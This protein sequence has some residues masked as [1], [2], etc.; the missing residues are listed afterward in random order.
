MGK[1]RQKKKSSKR[2]I[3]PL[4]RKVIEA[5]IREANSKI[6]IPT[7]EQVAPVVERLS[8]EDP[9]ERAWAAACI[10][11]LILANAATRK[12]LLSKGIVSTLIQRLADPQQEVRDESLGALRNI[13]SVE[14]TV[15]KEYYTRNI[16]E[17]LSA[18]LPQITQTIDMVLKKAPLEDEADGD[19]RK[20]IWD[21]TENF[22]Y[23]IWCISEASDKYIK[24]INRMNI[25]TFLSS[26]LISGE[27]I[28][29][30]VIIAAGQCLNTLTDDN[31]DLYIEFQ[32]HPEYVQTLLNI[33]RQQ[34]GN[35]LI[36]VL[37]CAILMNVRDVVNLSTSWD[38]DHQDMEELNKLVIPELVRALDYDIQ[39]AAN[40]TISAVQSGNV[41]NTQ[42]ESNE[43]TP[44]PKQP[45]TNEEIYVQ[46]VED[47]LSIT[48]LALELLADICVQDDELDDGFQDSDQVMQDDEDDEQP[49]QETDNDNDI[50]PAI[51]NNTAQDDE[52]LQ[53]NPVLHAYIHQ[54]FPQLIRLATATPISYNQTNLHPTVTHH[55][56]TTHQRSLE[57]LNNFLLAMHEVGDKYWFKHHKQD[58]TQLWRWLFDIANSVAAANTEEWARNAILEVVIG[59]LWAL[60]RGIA[61]DI[62]LDHMDVGA[63]CGTYETIPLETMSVKIVGCLGPIAMRLGDVETN[64]TIGMFIMKILE[65]K[66]TKASV[67]VEALNFMFDVYSDCAFDYDFPVFVQGGFLNR[68]KQIVP[69]VSSMVKSIDRRKDFDL[70]MRA[71]EAYENLNAFIKYKRIENNKRK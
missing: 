33:I 17:P 20:S 45:L 38:E 35:T 32:N 1:Q 56:V 59:C 67:M 53:S 57:C 34:H 58:A 52:A 9:T 47:R 16:M 12:L 23:I 46:G 42:D 48:Q 28:P 11:N 66:T 43:I 63:L 60:G 70:R 25:V 49:P 3:N 10:S 29:T 8:S 21:V 14:E 6:P 2:R 68:M 71:D 19:R 64:K 7:G 65:S 40:N 69:R 51:F 50:D 36:Q 41:H 26:F 15:A 13:A 4:Q 5:G 27:Q 30:R 37:A 39:E 54:I 61:Q 31:K 62:P 18:L 44:K 22:I 55:L 24:A